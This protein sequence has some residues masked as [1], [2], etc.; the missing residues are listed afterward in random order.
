MYFHKYIFPH[1]RNQS[2]MLDEM[3]LAICCQIYHI[4]QK[5]SHTYNLAIH[6]EA[7]NRAFH[8]A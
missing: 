3:T 1:F 6:F 2:F 4:I 7:I 5:K 8:Q